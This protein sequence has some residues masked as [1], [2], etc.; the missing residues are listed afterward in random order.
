MGTWDMKVHTDA[1]ASAHLA[2]DSSLKDIVRVK[3]EDRG[4][5]RA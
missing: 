5:E 3:L 2:G 4:G 1:Q